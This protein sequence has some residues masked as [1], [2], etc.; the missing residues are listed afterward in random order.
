MEVALLAV[1]R[2]RPYYREACDDYLRR[3]RRYLKVSEREVKEAA[4][5]PTDA[6]RRSEEAQRLLAA[7]P[8]GATLV[9]LDGGGEAWTS[10]ALAERVESW[11]LAARPVALVIGGSTGLA[12]ELL[13]RARQRWSLGPLTLPHELARVVVV[14][15]LYR[16]STIL[17]REP[18]HK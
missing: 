2:L 6:L 3:L 13:E 7:V 4:H 14:E 12:P 11:R 16:A 5:A 1:G 15:Q 10:E 17:R 18:Y 8:A 9:A